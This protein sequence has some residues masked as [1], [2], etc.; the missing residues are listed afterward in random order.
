M[1]IRTIVPLLASQLLGQTGSLSL[2]YSNDSN[3]SA[4]FTESADSVRLR[5]G[6]G[7]QMAL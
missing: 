3:S 2:W 1:R 4:D 6:L 5:G 7:R